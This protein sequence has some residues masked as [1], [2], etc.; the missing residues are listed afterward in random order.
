MQNVRLEAGGQ[1]SVF[2]AVAA[3]HWRF[4]GET[5][6]RYFRATAR[7]SGRSIVAQIGW[8]AAGRVSWVCAT[9]G[10]WA[11]RAGGG[12]RRGERSWASHRESPATDFGAGIR[13]VSGG[14]IR[15]HMSVV[16]GSSALICIRQAI[17]NTLSWVCGFGC[18]ERP[19]GRIFQ[20]ILGALR[21]ENRGTMLPVGNF[22]SEP[23][24]RSPGKPKIGRKLTHFSLQTC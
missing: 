5:R 12:V 14:K 6:S 18:R 17:L 20:P 19:D 15:R 16:T 1:R 9:A 4:G 13:R 10:D 7:S 11:Q 21:G 22:R 3:T 2:G 23:I 24:S 8:R